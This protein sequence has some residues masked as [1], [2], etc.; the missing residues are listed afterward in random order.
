MTYRQ[1]LPKPAWPPRIS[2]PPFPRPSPQ[3]TPDGPTLSHPARP[4]QTARRRSPPGSGALPR[5][6]PRRAG[7]ACRGVGRRGRRRGA[8]G[9]A[10][11]GAAP[12]GRLFFLW[13]LL[14]CLPPLAGLTDRV[15][16][17]REVLLYRVPPWPQPQ[18]L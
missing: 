13:A 15:W 2:Q 1:I 7:G 9:G 14:L 11:A 18:E 3:G 4:V 12:Q 16:T 8:L 17:L 5:G 10:P 6:L